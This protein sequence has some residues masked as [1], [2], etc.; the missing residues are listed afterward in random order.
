MYCKGVA[1]DPERMMWKGQSPWVEIWFAVVIDDSRRRAL[2]TR[3]SMFVPRQGEGRATI[4]IGWFDAD[5]E[6]TSRALKRYL[7]IDQAKAGD[8]DVLIRLGESWLGR[9]GTAGTVDGMAWDLAWEGGREISRDVPTWLPAPTHVQQ[10][11]HDAEATGKVTIGGAS[12][13]LRGRAIAMHLWGKRRL[14]TLHWIWAPWLDGSS[15]EVTA[16]SLRDRFAMGLATLRLDGPP[17]AEVS[18]AESATVL[19]V[20]PQSMRGRP[21]TA[22]HLQGMVTATV[23]GPRRLVHARAWAEPEAMVGYAYRD[24]DGRDLMVAQ[25]DIGSAFFEVYTRTAPGVPWRPIDERR[26][27]GGA[28]VEIHQRTP[29]PDVEYIAWDQTSH[30]SAKPPAPTRGEHH[31]DWPTLGTVVAFGLTY[32]DH[33]RETGQDVDPMKLPYAFEKHPRSFTVGSGG[34]PV[35]TSQ[36]LLAVLDALE[37]GL[38]AE[39]VERLQIV[40]AVMDYEGEIALVALDAIDT[41]ALAAGKPQPFGLAAAND[42]TARVCQV[43]GEN[44]D[45]TLEYWACAKS[46]PKFLPVAPFV[47]APP[48][49]I[50]KMPDLTIETKV[51]GERRQHASTTGLIYDLATIARAARD[52]LGRPLARGDVILTGTP[53]GV[54]L[55][56]SPLRRKIAELVKDRFKKIELLVATF[57]TSTELLRPGDV[58]EVDAGA[59]GRVRTRLTVGTVST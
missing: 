12:F 40:P 50:A 11:A 56:L 47:Y 18:S 41:D 44:T 59:A 33:A 19:R 36:E 6:A 35:P 13:D 8:G 25:S 23:A 20:R 15:L 21:A 14:P 29:L 24:T 32:R 10:I 45:R 38:R 52:H 30:V 58:I 4:W 57:A 5:A 53:A 37:P 3:Q 42:L 55:R 17:E 22:A 34:V 54:G 16:V 39:L 1:R 43:A 26:S 31:V 46:F 49:G 27:S 2:W 28:A 51:N 48:G 9:R 7:P